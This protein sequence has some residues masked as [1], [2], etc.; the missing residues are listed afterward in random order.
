MLIL[1]FISI[2]QKATNYKEYILFYF[3]R[4]PNKSDLLLF[5][6]H[7]SFIYYIIL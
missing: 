2:I 1:L 6:F 7:N 5:T 3:K 4:K